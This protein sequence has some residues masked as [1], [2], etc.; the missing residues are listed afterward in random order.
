MVYR[1]LLLS[2]EADS[3]KR[4]IRI[5]SQSTFLDFHEIILKA[6]GFDPNELY[7]FYVCGDDWHKQTEITQ[8]EMDT[9]SEED[10][11]IMENT[12]LEELITD[13]RQKLLYVFDQM[14]ERVFFIELLEIITG[15]NLKDPVCSKSTGN[16]P[17]QFLDYNKAALDIISDVDEDFY[18]DDAYDDEELEGFDKGDFN[19]PY[20]EEHF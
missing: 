16:P 8:I 10:C 9:S 11:F 19:D 14:S 7:T 6:T 13:E 2:D 15:K 12:T 4:E 17:K 18:G 3:F 1:F 5:S 20:S